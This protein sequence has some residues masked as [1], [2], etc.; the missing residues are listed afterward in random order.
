M[1]LT[2][3]QGKG[4][5]LTIQEMD[6]NLTYLEDLAEAGGYSYT[7][8][9]ISSAQIL[10]SGSIAVELL[11]QPGANKYYVWNGT[12]EYT[13][14]TIQYSHSGNIYIGG[15]GNK[16]G[17]VIAS[18]MITQAKNTAASFSSTGYYGGL[19]TIADLNE[20]VILKSVSL[21][22]TFG[23]GTI[24]IKLYYKIVTFG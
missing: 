18:A 8:I 11:A 2:T 15:N 13:Y 6:N 14:G 4:A 3:R 20:S 1:P 10:N 23:D 17:Q 9:S 21:N 5:K 16:H 19:G 7:E 12:F 22:P 24:K